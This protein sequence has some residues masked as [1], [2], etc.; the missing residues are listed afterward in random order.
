MYQGNSDNQSTRW[1]NKQLWKLFPDNFKI[2]ERM[3]E[4]YVVDQ[5][6]ILLDETRSTGAISDNLV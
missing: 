6:I 2:E 1:K 3:I 5:I 4:C